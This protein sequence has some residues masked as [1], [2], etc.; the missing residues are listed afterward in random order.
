MTLRKE[1]SN[2]YLKPQLL[3]GVKWAVGLILLAITISAFAQADF[4]SDHDKG[5]DQDFAP[6]PIPELKEFTRLDLAAGMIFLDGERFSIA[7]LLEADEALDS[8]DSHR[9]LDL[10]TLRR[11]EPVIV[12]TDGTAPSA[13]H[14]PRVLS[15]RRP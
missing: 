1:N 11:G 12:E 6:F 7:D 9:P 13:L 4:E 15:I 10:Q 3:Q 2:L 5:L 14:A 8:A